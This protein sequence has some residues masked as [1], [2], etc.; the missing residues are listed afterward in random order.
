M[1]K[2]II[3][4][5][6]VFTLDSCQ[7]E[8]ITIANNAQ[9]QFFLKN[10]GAEMPVF[11]N[12][13][14]ASGTFVIHLHGGPGGT[15]IPADE[16]NC[17][18]IIEESAAVVYWEQRCAGSSQ[19]NYDELTVN[20]YIT[21]LHKLISVMKYRYG[22]DIDIFLLGSS[23]GGAL[24]LFYL[25]TSDYQKNIKG[26]ILSAALYNFP[27]VP[28]ARLE[29]VKRYADQQISSGSKVSDW[30]E[31]ITK[32]SENEASNGTEYMI[33]NGLGYMAEFLMT[34][35]DSVK[36]LN[37]TLNDK[38]NYLLFSNSQYIASMFNEFETDKTIW[39]ELIQYDLTDK[40]SNITIPM[41]LYWG[42]YDFVSTDIMAESLFS[43]LEIPEKEI[44]FYQNSGHGVPGDADMTKY[45]QD[46]V[47]FIRRYK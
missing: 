21:D 36:P 16:F 11:V 27:E 43:L 5:L 32:M 18:S 38:L 31:I 14:T 17:Y 37:L 7:K 24:A 20:K 34:D 39:D 44:I 9:D 12:G 10:D 23:W 33:H 35:V 22:S 26:C 6:I 29:M 46:V 42:K 19:G 40:I 13:N 41:A 15:A 2:I 4:I 25:T 45:N 1:K 8:K 47:S 30:N 3:G 28:N